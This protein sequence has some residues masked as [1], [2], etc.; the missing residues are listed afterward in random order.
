MLNFFYS[1]NAELYEL[2]CD[3]EWEI[4]RSQI[5]LREQLGEGAFGLVMRGDAVGLPDMP[6]TCSVAVKMLKGRFHRYNLVSRPSCQEYAQV[7]FSSNNLDVLHV[8]SCTSI[9]GP[10]LI[11]PLL[12]TVD[13]TPQRPFLEKIAQLFDWLFLRV[14]DILSLNQ[15]NWKKY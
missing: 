5:T 13:I 6:S 1:F 2:P 3:E 9:K 10:K 7:E 8:L 15:T 11:F 4:D 14:S 12:R